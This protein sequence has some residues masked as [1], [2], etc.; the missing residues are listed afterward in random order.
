MNTKKDTQEPDIMSY[1][2]DEVARSLRK[3]LLRMLSY[4]PGDR[5]EIKEVCEYI[6]KSIRS[7]GA[8]SQNLIS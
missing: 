8:S 1:I 2:H 5:P 4:Y 3:F 6:E 7:T